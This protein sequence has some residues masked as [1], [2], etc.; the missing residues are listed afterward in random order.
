MKFWITGKAAT[1]DAIIAAVE[2]G[3]CTSD[4]QVERIARQHGDKVAWCA[5]PMPMP[6]PEKQTLPQ[7]R[8]QTVDAI[9]LEL[10]IPAN[11]AGHAY[12]KEAVDIAGKLPPGGLQGKITSVIYPR[13]AERFGTTASRV[14]RATRHA[15]EKSFSQCPLDVITKYFGNG[16]SADKG[17]AT[18]SEFIAGIVHHLQMGNA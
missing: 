16:Y 10:G 6:T 13:I 17:K 5:T 15:V 4:W 12:L 3:K 8:P 11:I 14:E 7:Q 1:A 2:A 18:N 9:L